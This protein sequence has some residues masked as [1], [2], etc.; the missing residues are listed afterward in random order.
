MNI[1]SEDYDNSCYIFPDV[2][3]QLPK[4]LDTKEM[5]YPQNKS[6]NPPDFSGICSYVN[7][8]VSFRETQI[9]HTIKIAKI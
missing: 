2:S 1:I 7:R 8:R 6:Q 4:S 5:K 9:T 3:W